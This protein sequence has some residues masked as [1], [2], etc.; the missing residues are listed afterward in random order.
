MSGKASKALVAAMAGALSMS[1]TVLAAAEETTQLASSATT[2]AAPQAKRPVAALPLGLSA[3]PEP[4]D[5]R[6]R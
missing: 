3:R 2:T 5:S 4:C 6:T 1:L